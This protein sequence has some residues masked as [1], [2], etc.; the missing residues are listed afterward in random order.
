MKNCSSALATW[1]F[2]HITALDLQVDGAAIPVYDGLAPETVQGSYIVIGE[3]SAVKLPNKA[4]YTF[5]ANILL[6][7][8][9]KN[10]SFGYQTGDNIASQIL[11]SV[12]SD[13]QPDL[14][15]DFQ[16]IATR[17]G[18]PFN[19]SSLNNTEPTFRTLIRYNHLISQI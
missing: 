7:I 13:N 17:P 2:D 11:A 9:I 10:G 12:D 5:D 16:C 3:R 1:W 4:G 14:S 6:D 19:L 8:V 18:T 15:P